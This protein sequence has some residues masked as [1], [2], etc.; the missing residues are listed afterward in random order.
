VAALLAGTAA[1]LAARYHVT[2]ADGRAAAAAHLSADFGE[3][4][5]DAAVVTHAEWVLSHDREHLFELQLPAK[6]I[7]SFMERLRAA[8]KARRYYEDSPRAVW[9]QS[10]TPRWWDNPAITDPQRF[11]FLRTKGRGDTD[12]YGFL[13]SPTTGRLFMTWKEY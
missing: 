9:P 13:Y 10:G 5:P 6:D 7:G 8:A 4:L 2:Y 12:Q 11:Q 1:L 3:P